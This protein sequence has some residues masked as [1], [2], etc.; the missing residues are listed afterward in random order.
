MR[1][2]VVRVPSPVQIGG[3]ELATSSHSSVVRHEY[4]HGLLPQQG[5]RGGRGQGDRAHAPA[6]AKGAQFTDD[7]VTTEC[8]SL[9]K[10]NSGVVV[11]FL[12]GPWESN[13][14]PADAAAFG[15]ILLFAVPCYALA[16]LALIYANS[17]R[18]RL[19]LIHAIRR[20]DRAPP[21]LE[22]RSAKAPARRR[23]DI[24]P[25]ARRSPGRR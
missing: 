20:A 22:R 1:T 4:V 8:S 10:L 13:G 6:Y 2:S 5:S 17:S 19:S 14:P 12:R 11:V 21:Y 7:N 3:A 15:E 25:Q 23:P 9:T 16:A 18:A 24:F